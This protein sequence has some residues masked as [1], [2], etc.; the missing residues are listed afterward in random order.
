MLKFIKG[1]A[2]PLGLNSPTVK[3]GPVTFSSYALALMTIGFLQ[4]R[5]SCGTSISD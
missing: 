3:G 5:V 2:K 1:W 4:V